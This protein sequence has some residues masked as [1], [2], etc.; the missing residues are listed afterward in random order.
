[1][2]VARGLIVALALAAGPLAMVDAAAAQMSANPPEIGA[3]I[4]QMGPDLT[5]DMV[6]ATNQLYAPL[7]AAAPKDGVRVVRDVKY[8]PHARNALD[9]Y[10][11]EQSSSAPPPIVVFAHGGGFVRGDKADVANVGAYFARHGVAAI[12]MNYRLAPESTWPSG[13]EDVAALVRWIKANPDAHRGDVRRIVLAGNSAGA[14]HIAAYAFYEE[15]QVADDGVVGAILI[16]SPAVNL[17]GRTIDPARDALYYGTDVSRHAQMSAVN[18]VAGRRIPLFLSVGEI[19][20]PLAHEQNRE[21][22]AALFERDKRLPFFKTAL[23]HNHISIVEHINTAD[24]S[25]GRDMLEFI[26]TAQPQ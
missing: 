2:N 9:L 26:R 3:K 16:S 4:R 8:G 23:G 25:L 11:P 17:V 21:L 6:Q 19:D 12:L 20:I 7:H 18:H 5:R 22:M 15:H 14:M 13:P 24:D 1:M 10:A